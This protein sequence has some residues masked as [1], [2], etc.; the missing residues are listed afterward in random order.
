MRRI[1]KK[2]DHHQELNTE[3]YGQLM[4]YAAQLRVNSPES[5]EL[6]YNKYALI[7][8]QEFATYLPRFTSGIDDLI[9]FL[10]SNPEIVSLLSNSSVPLSYFPND[11]HNYLTYTFNGRL[12]T[13]S[14][15]PVLNLIKKAGKAVFE[16]PQ[17]RDNDIVLKYEDSNPYKETGLKTHF[18]RLGKYSFITRLQT[19]RYLTRTKASFDK[20]EYLYPDRLGSIFTNKDKSI[21]FYIFLTEADTNKAQNAC[22]LLNLAFY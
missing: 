22:Q 2:L 21:Y 7:L 1:L 8:Y 16:L 3:E 9:N 10:I 5:Y 11:L 17:P 14:L 12:D 20:F 13:D 4:E 19:Y 15:A 6:F 18:D